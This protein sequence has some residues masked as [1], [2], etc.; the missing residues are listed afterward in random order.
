MTHTPC[1][2]E[3]VTFLIQ[4]GQFAIDHGRDDHLLTFE[5]AHEKAASHLHGR[6][7]WSV[8]DLGLS[9]AQRQPRNSSQG[10]TLTTLIEE[11]LDSGY[12]IK[13]SCYAHL[14][15]FISM[16]DQRLWKVSG[17]IH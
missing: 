7:P 5:P 1:R 15:H 13:S 10:N 17:S 16:S 4:K 3:K 8:P 9:L 2:G 11:Y 6:D 12:D 14:Q